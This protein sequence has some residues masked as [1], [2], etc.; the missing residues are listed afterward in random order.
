MKSL[1]FYKINGVVTFMYVILIVCNFFSEISFIFPLSNLFS[2]LP[3]QK[4]TCP[5]L[6]CDGLIPL[7]EQRPPFKHFSPLPLP[8]LL[9]FNCPCL[10]TVLCQF[11]P[12]C[13]LIQSSVSSWLQG[14]DKTIDL[15]CRGQTHLEPPAMMGIGC[16]FQVMPD[17]CQMCICL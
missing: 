12:L 4:L 7:P 16:P 2:T 17:L 13:N 11:Y 3:R 9:S 8:T 5:H 14:H 6:P 15:T 10:Y 1:D